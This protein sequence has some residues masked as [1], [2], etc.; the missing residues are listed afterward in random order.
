MYKVRMRHPLWDQ[1]SRYVSGVIREHADYVGS[2]T[3]APPYLSNDEWF[4]LTEEDGNVR[5][6]SKDNVICSW[7]IPRSSNSNPINHSVR[8]IRGNKSY[9]VSLS[10]SGRLACNCTSYGFRRT[11]SHIQEVEAAIP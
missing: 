10:P 7:R 4:T 5:I 3:D 9:T 11:C 6:L 8:I 2:V 1:R